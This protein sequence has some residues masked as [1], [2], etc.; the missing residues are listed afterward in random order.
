MSVHR[1]KTSERDVTT[2]RIYCTVIDHPMEEPYNKDIDELL[3]QPR[4]PHFYVFLE[5][6]HLSKLFSSLLTIHSRY[7]AESRE[8]RLRSKKDCTGCRLLRRG[9]KK[10]LEWHSNMASSRESNQCSSSFSQRMV[11]WSSEEKTNM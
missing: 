1:L 4:P 6:F 11:R 7:E 3:F 8:H 10:I 9:F 5:V 2:S